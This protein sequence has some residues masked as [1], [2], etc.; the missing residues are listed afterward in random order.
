[1][2]Y[3]LNESIKYILS[4][5]FVLNEDASTIVSELDSL[6]RILYDYVRYN[7]K[8]K[9]TSTDTENIKIISIS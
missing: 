2:K 7:K 8:S 3:Y 9:D 4:E 5:R 1:M 6:Y